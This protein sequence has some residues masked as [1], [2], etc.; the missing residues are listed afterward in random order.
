MRRL[1]NLFAAAHAFEVAPRSSPG[2]IRE[3]F[4]V[5]RSG[6]DFHRK[7]HFI[8]S[9]LATLAAHAVERGPV[10]RACSASRWFCRQRA[11]HYA[12]SPPPI[13]RCL[14]KCGGD[15]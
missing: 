9:R 2:E 11:L 3:D 15:D 4:T 6:Y 7:A 10:V 5:K 1:A 8:S 13:P 14:C 12:F